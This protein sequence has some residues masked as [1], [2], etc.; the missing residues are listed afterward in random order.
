M[1]FHLW[2]KGC[3]RARVP[4][5]LA[6]SVMRSLLGFFTKQIHVHIYYCEWWVLSSLPEEADA[7][8]MAD[9]WNYVP[10]T[11]MEMSSS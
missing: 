6:A 10:L 7:G 2:L 5:I 3:R 8:A 9:P 1:H 11:V 4:L